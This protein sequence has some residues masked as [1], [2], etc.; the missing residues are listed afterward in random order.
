VEFGA[1]YRDATSLG[2]M[3]TDDRTDGN[4][5]SSARRRI[6]LDFAY[7]STTPE[8]TPSTSFESSAEKLSTN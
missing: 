7:E 2:N 3:S 8:D 6:A 5:T 1:A 4:D